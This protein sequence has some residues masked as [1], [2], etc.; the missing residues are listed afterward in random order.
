LAQTEEEVAG[1]A[2]IDEAVAE[3]VQVAERERRRRRQ[4]TEEQENSGYSTS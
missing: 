2:R 1:V 3:D 4:E